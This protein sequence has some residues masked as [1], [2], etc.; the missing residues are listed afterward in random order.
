MLASAFADATLPSRHAFAPTLSSAATVTPAPA[1]GHPFYM[2]RVATLT[3]PTDMDHDDDAIDEAEERERREATAEMRQGL[4]LHASSLVRSTDIKRPLLVMAAAPLPDSLFQLVQH[5]AAAAH[6]ASSVLS[7]VSALLTNAPLAAVTLCGNLSGSTGQHFS[8]GSGSSNGSGSGDSS[9]HSTTNSGL[10]AS[11]LSATAGMDSAIIRGATQPYFE[12]PLRADGLHLAQTPIR[13]TAT[14]APSSLMLASLATSVSTALVSLSPV[15]SA[16]TGMSGAL[17]VIPRS[18]TPAVS[19]GSVSG[20]SVSAGSIVAQAQQD[21][22]MV[23]I[24]ENVWHSIWCQLLDVM[25]RCASPRQP[26]IELLNIALNFV[27]QHESLLLRLLQTRALHRANLRSHEHIVSLFARLLAHQDRWSVQHTRLL[28]IIRQ[29]V[30]HLTQQLVKVLHHPELPE[31]AS[32]W[33]PVLWAEMRQKEAQHAKVDFF[34]V[35]C[36]CDLSCWLYRL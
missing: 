25:G 31:H 36:C 16:S 33:E 15:V 11:L 8:G 21:R 23:S 20:A 13:A 24:A 26:P 32:R 28:P 10:L 3:D 4:R 2:D 6:R 29:A 22:G 30:T 35:Q 7:F 17:A 27:L 18:L 12:V 14:A 9:R 1:I 34:F 19:V 5:N